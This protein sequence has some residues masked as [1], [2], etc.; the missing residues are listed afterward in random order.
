VLGSNVAQTLFGGTS[1]VVGQNVRINGQP[2]RVIGVLE[3]KGGTGFLNQDDQVIVP[4]TTMQT[5]LSGASFFRGANTVNQIN[6]QVDS[7]KN[8][9][10]TMSLVTEALRQR[11]NT[12]EGTDDFT[13][14]SQ[15]ES[16]SAV[17]SVTNTL[18]IFLAGI[19]GISLL[20]GGIGIM[21]IMLTTVTERTHEIGLR[22]AIGARRR[23]ILLQ[24]LVESMV[25]SLLGGL[26]GVAVGWGIA[27]LIGQVQLGGNAI[28]PV[29]GIDTVLIA[30]LFSM[31]IGLFF[32]IYPATRASRLQ[33]VDA[34][35]YE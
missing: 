15:Q 9:T 13:I 7:P 34:L 28:T 10:P 12:T 18:S 24:F 35:R 30:T 33:P 11:H 17:T 5:R 20:V 22:K 29:V 1:G 3:S 27:Q 16:L 19:A 2:Y 6:I 32:G 21:N 26:L 14:T 31:A 4:L 23:D 25:L 8:V